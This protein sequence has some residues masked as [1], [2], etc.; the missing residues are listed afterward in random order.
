MEITNQDWKLFRQQ[1]PGWQEAYMDR[2]NREYA[3]ILAGEG[4]PSE[5]F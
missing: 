2:L 4:N 3:E 1:L 5:K